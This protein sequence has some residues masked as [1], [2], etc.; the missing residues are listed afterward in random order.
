[1]LDME[2]ASKMLGFDVASI[3][4]GSDDW[5]K[6][7]L[8]VITGSKVH[9]ILSDPRNKSDR[10]AGKLSDSSMTYMYE[11]VSE[12]G[13]GLIPDA[14]NSKPLLWGRENEST[15]RE[16]FEFET[17][18]IVKEMPFIYKDESMRVGV[19][20][21]GMCSDGRGIEIKSPYTSSQFARFFV[22]GVNAVKPEYMAQVQFSM[23][24]SSIDEWYFC[25]YDCRYKKNNISYI[26]IKKDNFYF[27][28]FERRIPIF[29]EK[30]D[31]VLSVMG[32]SYGNQWR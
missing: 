20:P 14:I 21:D 31:E 23:W 19:S 13:T 7:R 11:L 18:L 16:I 29:I 3:E 24:V 10:E 22:E 32:E 30:M 15:A 5:H 4:Q 25:N 17:G 1:M 9:A 12:V 28:E 26:V 27:D 2:I 6:M 8:G